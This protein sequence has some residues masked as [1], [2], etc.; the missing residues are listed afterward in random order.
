MAAA[1]ACWNTFWTK[2][3]PDDVFA[4]DTIKFV[5]IRDRRLGILHYLFTLGILI[6]VIGIVLLAQKQFLAVE[7]PIAHIRLSLLPRSA[8]AIASPYCSS[9]PKDDYPQKYPCLYLNSQEIVI[10]PTGEQLFLTTHMST[11]KFARS[12]NVTDPSCAETVVQNTTEYVVAD[13]ESLTMSIDHSPVAPTLGVVI[14]GTIKGNLQKHHSGN[15]W[16][17]AKTLPTTLQADKIN[18]TD[19]LKAAGVNLDSK[20]NEYLKGVQPLQTNRAFGAVILFMIKYDNIDT[21]YS[22]VTNID[23]QYRP[24]WV[25]DIEDYSDVSQ[26]TGAD[27][28]ARTLTRHRGVRFVGIATGAMGAFRFQTLLLQLT[29]SLALVKIAQLVV[30]ILA[31]RFL[32][33]KQLYFDAKYE[34]TEDFS[35]LAAKRKAERR[36]A[37]ERASTEL[38]TAVTGAGHETSHHGFKT[39]EEDDDDVEGGAT[40]N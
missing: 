12:C 16:S 10:P 13:V 7:Q 32:P 30:D 21:Y 26:Y 36:A 37:R 3:D 17:K 9:A 28:T 20:G 2:H 29:T 39:Q 24:Y 4:Y 1:G 33:R 25:G 6:Y 18:V 8:P 14:D 19:I 22:S 35:V 40:P 38:E 27:Y 11:T 34:K 23:Y 15:T 5:K 31:T